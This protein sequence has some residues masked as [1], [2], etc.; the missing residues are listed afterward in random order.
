[1]NY[2]PFH[3]GDYASAT[4]H[5]SWDEDCAYRRLLDAYYTTEKPLP[6]DERA[7]CRLVLATTQDQREA[8]M[9]VLSEFWARTDSGWVN[10]RADAEIAA[11]REKQQKQRDK[12]NK[13]WLM[14]EPERGSASAMPQ[15]PEDDA[16][17]FVLDAVA[18]PPTP[19]PTPTPTPDKNPSGST[20]E[21]P[22][23]KQRGTK[24]VPPDFT[25]TADMQAWAEEDA[26]LIDWRRETEKFRD[27]EF[28]HSRTDWPATWRTW[29]RKAQEDRE[30]RAPT[31]NRTSTGVAL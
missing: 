31:G 27:W 5:L 12:A 1:V 15:H 26:P 24:R 25:V 20:P 14:P 7:V 21:K 29:M 9:T 18:M 4:R 2:Y 8:V 23:R 17:A 11:M 10:R 6:L 28:K 30:S 16:A 13:R 22:A 19:T 3:I